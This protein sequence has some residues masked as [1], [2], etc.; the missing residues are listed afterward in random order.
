MSAPHGAG[1]LRRSAGELLA[2]SGL[3]PAEARSLLAHVSGW[4][5]EALVA[6][7]QYER[8]EGREVPA[9]RNC[10]GYVTAG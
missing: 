10:A 2:A 1:A 7:I 4:R 5:R 9:P 6:F 8:E 3:P